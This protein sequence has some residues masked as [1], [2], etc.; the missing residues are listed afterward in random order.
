MINW[1]SNKKTHNVNGGVNNEAV[2]I[3]VALSNN[4]PNDINKLQIAEEV[5][6]LDKL[7]VNSLALKN[8]NDIN[9][10][11]N[12]EVR[13][14][15]IDR[16][17]GNNKTLPISGLVFNSEQPDIFNANLYKTKPIQDNKKSINNV[18]YLG[19]NNESKEAKK[20]ELSKDF[21]NINNVSSEHV[22]N[23]YSNILDKSSIYVM[24]DGSKFIFRD[25]NKTYLGYFSII[26]LI[27]YIIG[28]EDRNNYFIEKIY[29]IQ[30]LNPKIY[31]DSKKLIKNFILIRINNP[32]YGVECKSIKLQSFKKSPFMADLQLLIHL[33]ND[34]LEFEKAFNAVYQDYIS[35]QTYRKMYGLQNNNNAANINLYGNINPEINDLPEIDAKKIKLLINELIYSILVY[36]VKLIG[37]VTLKLSKVPLTKN[38]YQ[39]INKIK[40]SLHLYTLQIMTKISEC[41]RATLMNVTNEEEKLGKLLFE[42]NKIK[43][44]IY[45]KIGDIGAEITE[46]Y[47]QLSQQQQ[48]QQLQQQQQQQQ[49]LQQQQ[50]QQLQQQQHEFNTQYFQKKQSPYNQM[51]QLPNQMNQLPNQMNQLPNQM[52]QQPNLMNQQPNQMNQLQNQMDLPKTQTR[53]IYALVPAKTN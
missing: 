1:K 53:N 4:N 14:D 7:A 42:S 20:K 13:S 40:N 43:H 47:Q 49:Q 10:T 50:Q 16:L 29:G 12:S 2:D 5:K 24:Y 31:R 22:R 30:T 15:N 32:A 44:R 37:I 36:T 9:N 34:I 46:S 28:K 8:Q 48:Q 51:N 3:E 26:E 23:F 18:G 17:L 45:N 33:N 41:T 6:F 38:N 21:F 25:Y 39:K 27:R 35:H 11:I 19:N 52:N